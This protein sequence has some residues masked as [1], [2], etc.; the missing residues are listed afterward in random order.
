MASLQIYVPQQSSRI[1]KR[2]LV[3]SPFLS[4]PPTHNNAITLLSLCSHAIV[5]LESWELFV[6]ILCSFNSTLSLDIIN[7][8]RGASERILFC[9]SQQ[10]HYKRTR[11]FAVS[12][13]RFG[14]R[15]CWREFIVREDK[16]TF[17]PSSMIT[18]TF[19]Q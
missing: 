10:S 2:A 3:H 1:S 13:V 14:F 5:T 18:S 15:C 11:S 4:R 12:S 6:N 16:S 19:I 7:C 9:S 17:S 8:W